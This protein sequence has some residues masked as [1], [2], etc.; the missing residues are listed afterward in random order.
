[1]PGTGTPAEQV[2]DFN[3]GI[4]ASG[5]F[6]TVPAEDRDLQ[7]SRSGR[8]AVLEMHDVPV[9]DSFQFFGR[10]QVPATISCR[11]EWEATGAFVPRG[12]GRAVEPTDMAAFL[13]HIAPA[14][15]RGWFEG[16]EWGFSFESRH[17]TTAGGWAQLGQVR[18]GDFLA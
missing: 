2:H 7:V 18:N 13:G 15:S 4:L 1:M 6:W 9:L 3:G 16:E 17:A 8:R 14:R 5:L 10:S 11:V 12:S